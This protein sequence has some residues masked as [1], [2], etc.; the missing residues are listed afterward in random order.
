MGWQGA[1]ADR[2]ER[3]VDAGQAASRLQATEIHDDNG[4]IEEAVQHTLVSVPVPGKVRPN[5]KV[6]RIDHV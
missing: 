3:V 2:L 6:F 5:D 4:S 1:S